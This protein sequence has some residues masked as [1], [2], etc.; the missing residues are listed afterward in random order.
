MSRSFGDVYE[1]QV[2]QRRV[3]DVHVELFIPDHQVA[4]IIGYIFTEEFFPHQFCPRS[5][6]ARRVA[7]LSQLSRLVF[8]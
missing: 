2:A 1:R 3:V 4:G 7:L 6:V 8:L 5:I